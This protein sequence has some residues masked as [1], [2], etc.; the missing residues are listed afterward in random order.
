M[1]INVG[2]PTGNGAPDFTASSA[3]PTAPSAGPTIAEFG[4]LQGQLTAL[5]AQISLMKAQIGSEQVDVGLLSFGSLRE[6]SS[7][8]ASHQAIK[9]YSLF[10]CPISL[11]AVSSHGLDSLMDELKFDD[12]SSKRGKTPHKRCS[13]SRFAMNC[14]RFLGNCLNLEWP[15]IPGLFQPYQPTATGTLASV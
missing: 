2:A 9:D 14:P 6:A 5:Q 10:V 8:L 15:A 12:Y 11:M 3:N 13:S 4:A 7:F 1:N